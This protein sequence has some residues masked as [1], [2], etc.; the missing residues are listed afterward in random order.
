[1]SKDMM[2]QEKE[3][4]RGRK[5]GKKKA[6]VEG[7]GRKK[8]SETHGTEGTQIYQKLHSPSFLRG[9]NSTTARGGRER[10]GKEENEPAKVEKRGGSR[11]SF[12]SH[13]RKGIKGPAGR[14]REREGKH[15]LQGEQWHESGRKWA[16]IKLDQLTHIRRNKPH[17]QLLKSGGAHPKPGGKK[18][19][20]NRRENPIS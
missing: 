4:G 3:V 13:P 11:E 9:K 12:E 1:M 20:K 15:C 6:S 16:G 18:K 19:N 17:D 10:P 8:K 14:T 5:P 7:T 2:L